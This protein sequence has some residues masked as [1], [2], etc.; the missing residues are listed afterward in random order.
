MKWARRWIENLFRKKVD[1]Y[2]AKTEVF[3]HLEDTLY[4]K[5]LEKIIPDSIFM[6]LDEETPMRIVRI[7]AIKEL[8]CEVNFIVD[9]IRKGN[10]YV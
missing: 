2:L 9:T 3:E 4:M 10:W 1:D 8:T 7:P 5:E 6:K